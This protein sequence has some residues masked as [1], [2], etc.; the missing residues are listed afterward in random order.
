MSGAPSERALDA[1][2]A[3]QLTVAWAGEGLCEPPR[4]GW[5]QTDLVDE[6]GGGDLLARLLPRTHRWAALEAVR[7][8]ATQ[9]DSKARSALARPDQV[10]TLFFWGFEIDEKI[11]DRL[12]WHKRGQDEPQEALPF[13]VEIDGDFSRPALEDLLRIPDSNHKVVP[14]GREVA[15]GSSPDLEHQ[16]R[17]LAAAL[18][19]LAE[20]YP[21]P[22]FR[23]ES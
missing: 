1:V 11:S 20:S 5:W 9:A 17:R 19:P 8:A 22:F 2:L 13:E 21:M 6:L 23:V 16:S 10:R 7:Q 4:L 14:G 3:L 12:A 15:A 18:L